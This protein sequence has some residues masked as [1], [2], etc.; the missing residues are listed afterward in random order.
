MNAWDNT[1]F[2]FINLVNR[3]DRDKQFRVELKNMNILPNKIKK[4]YATKTKKGFI[5]CAISHLRTIQIGLT[6]N[7]EFIFIFED[8]FQLIS[9]IDT[10]VN[11]INFFWTYFTDANVLMLQINPLKIRKTEIPNFFKVERA[12]SAAGYMIKRSY[13]PML[14]LNIRE[15]LQFNIP[16]D[17]GYTKIQHDG[18]YT[19]FPTMGRQRPSYSDIEKKFVDYG[20]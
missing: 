3:T 2:F 11:Y 4:I 20:L 6:M 17:V 8:D 18:W 15:S 10:Y 19:I 7:S 5:G 1:F 13:L 9:D 16:L 12:L 14:S